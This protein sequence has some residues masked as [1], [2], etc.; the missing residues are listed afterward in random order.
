MRFEWGKRKKVMLA[1]LAQ[2][3]SSIFCGFCSKRRRHGFILHGANCRSSSH[4][5]E[6]F[7]KSPLEK[8]TPP[9]ILQLDLKIQEVFDGER[10]ANIHNCSTCC[11]ARGTGK[12]GSGAHFRNSEEEACRSRDSRMQSFFWRIRKILS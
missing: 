6:S 12:G 4:S 8:S 1:P 2:K 10:R 5:I 3:S 9:L 7:A 11:Y